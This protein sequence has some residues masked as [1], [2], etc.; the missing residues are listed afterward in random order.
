M[1]KE[2]AGVSRSSRMMEGETKVPSIPVVPPL[3]SAGPGFAKKNSS[4]LFLLFEVWLLLL[5]FVCFN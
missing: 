1:G 5:L 4:C 2:D 3:T